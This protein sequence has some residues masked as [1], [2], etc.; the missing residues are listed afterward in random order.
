[1]SR[2]IV[3]QSLAQP[4][5]VAPVTVAQVAVPGAAAVAATVTIPATVAIP[6]TVPAVPPA[7]TVTETTGLLTQMIN[8]ETYWITY[9]WLKFAI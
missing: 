3:K 2:C 8:L 6:A 9:F 1:M 4:V 7:Q 5:A